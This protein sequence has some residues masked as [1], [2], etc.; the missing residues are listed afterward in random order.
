[1][2][3]VNVYIMSAV[4]TVRF[5]DEAS[6]TESSRTHIITANSRQRVLVR[7]TADAPYKQRPVV[8]LCASVTQSKLRHI[9]ARDSHST[10]NRWGQEQTGLDIYFAFLRAY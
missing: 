6:L 1:M 10:A 8:V 5:A 7:L 3:K 9:N 2:E 4:R